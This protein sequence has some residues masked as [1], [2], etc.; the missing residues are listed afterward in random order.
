MGP[1]T[2][3]GAEGDKNEDGEKAVGDLG[4]FTVPLLIDPFPFWGISPRIRLRDSSQRM[5]SGNRNGLF[6]TENGICVLNDDKCNQ[7]RSQNILQM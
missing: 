7:L 2:A 5:C 1:N 4:V 3:C 6:S